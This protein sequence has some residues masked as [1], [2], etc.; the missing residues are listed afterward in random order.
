[1]GVSACGAGMGRHFSN[2]PYVFEK[3]R[4][5]KMT[6]FALRVEKAHG[7]AFSTTY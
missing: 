5:A 7:R 2:M 1:M 6:F 3:W 4:K